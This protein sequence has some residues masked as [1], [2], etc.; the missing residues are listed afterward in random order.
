MFTVSGISADICFGIISAIV[1]WKHVRPTTN[2]EVDESEVFISLA[3]QRRFVG[4]VQSVD[5]GAVIEE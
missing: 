1:S 4:R 5:V 2:Q 3:S